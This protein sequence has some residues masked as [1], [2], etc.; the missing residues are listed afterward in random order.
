MATSLEAVVE[1]L[2]ARLMG[3]VAVKVEARMALELGIVHQELLEEARDYRAQGT[4]SGNSVAAS[5]VL[6]F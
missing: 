3:L 1:T 2:V 6:L 4:E 5:L